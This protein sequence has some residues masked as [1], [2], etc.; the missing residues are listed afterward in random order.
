MK[1]IFHGREARVK[2][3]L[4]TDRQKVKIMSVCD[5]W[6]LEFIYV[7]VLSEFLKICLNVKRTFR[8]FFS[9]KL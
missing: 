4:T 5:V 9:C 2:Y 3:S 6:P 1:W 7:F 8:L